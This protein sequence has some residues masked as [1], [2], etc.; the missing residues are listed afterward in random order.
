MSSYQIK[1]KN[2]IISISGLSFTDKIAVEHSDVTNKNEFILAEDVNEIKRAVN[3]TLSGFSLFSRTISDDLSSLQSES[4]TL[5]QSFNDLSEQ[6][7]NIQLTNSI[8]LS[9]LTE[10]FDNYLNVQPEIND[11]ISYLSSAIDAIS[12]RG[13]NDTELRGRIETLEQ[14]HSEDFSQFVTAVNELSGKLKNL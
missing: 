7:F 12:E 13:Y 4:I 14:I 3:D 8:K 9:S 10:Q 5:N 2:D 11:K 6:I 1:N